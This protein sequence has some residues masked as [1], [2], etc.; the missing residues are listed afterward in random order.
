[1]ANPSLYYPVK[2]KALNQAFGAN[3]EYY[4]SHFGLKGHDGLDLFA[5]HGTPVYAAHDGE[6]IYLKDA[7]GGEGIYLYADGFLTE[8]W[9][10]IG[11][12]DTKFPLPVPFDSGYHKIQA[13]DLI[14]FSDNTGAPF[15]SSGDHLH[16]GLAFTDAQN[17]AINSDNGYHGFVDPTPYFNGLFAQDIPKPLTYLQ[18]LI[19]DIA[20]MIKSRF[21]S[22]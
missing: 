9:H 10:L 19:N 1:M 4:Q 20:Y 11:D 12:T 8:Y 6:A 16:F 21:T 13:G 18:I 2:P 14:G 15:E 22:K 5:A 3:P 7:H 17:Q